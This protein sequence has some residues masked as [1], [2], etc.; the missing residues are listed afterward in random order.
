LCD[1]CDA[2][3]TDAKLEEKPIFSQD[4]DLPCPACSESLF[5]E[6]SHWASREEIEAVGWLATALGEGSL[7]LAQ[8]GRL[9]EEQR[10][11]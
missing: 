9:E 8:G 7:T 2:V 10:D 5:Q 1:E 6:A 11:A 4:P 3:W